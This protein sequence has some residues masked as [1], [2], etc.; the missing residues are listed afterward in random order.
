[1]KTNQIRIRDP[2]ILPVK[3]EN[4]Y[5]LYGTTD[6]NVWKGAG[7]GFDVYRSSDLENWQG[8]FPAFRPT[9]N[10]WADHHFWAPEVHVYQGQYYMLASFKAEGKCRGT[11]ILKADHPLGPFQPLTETP[12]TPR[13]WECLDGTLYI[14]KD[15]QPWLIFCHEWVQVQD[16]KI[17]AQRLSSDLSCAVGEPVELFRASKAKWSVPVQ[18][19]NYVTDGPFIHSNEQGELM[20]LWSSMA[21]HG[22]AIG[23]AR[24]K[25]NTI[26]GP[27]I[28]DDHAWLDKEGGHGMLF[29]TFEGQLMLTIHS[30]NKTPNERPVFIK[31]NENRL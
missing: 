24:S 26:L 3:N 28:Q 22:Y 18:G 13:H 2:F 29:Q 1:M 5:Y 20:M 19:N 25:S 9:D 6:S 16:G 23:L 31:I 11:Q 17:C 7:T 21:E 27:W 15:E 12:V 14:D 10:F 4:M 8:P 30:P